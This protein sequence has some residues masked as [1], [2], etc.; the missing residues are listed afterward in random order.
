[1]KNSFKLELFL[2]LSVFCSTS[3]LAQDQQ[4]NANFEQNN[5]QSESNNVSNN[6][7]Q[8]A[9]ETSQ[10]DEE[11]NVQNTSLNGNSNDL[12]I[13]NPTNS[14]DTGSKGDELG[15]GENSGGNS[16]GNSTEPPSNVPPANTSAPELP[17]SNVPSPSG[18][19]VADPG[20]APSV[21]GQAQQVAIPGNPVAETENAD[22]IFKL[23][24]PLA[25]NEFTGAPSVPG[26]IKAF[27]EGEA[28]DLYRVEPGDT[29]I[30]ICDQLL[31]E[32]G[33]WPKLW[34]YNPDIRNPHFIWPG[35][36]LKF[37]SG[38][39]ETP[40]YL[41]ISNSDPMLPTDM[42]AG[43]SEASL[44]NS[45]FVTASLPQAKLEQIF[46]TDPDSVVDSM[47]VTSDTTGIDYYGSP[48]AVLDL[49]VNV[50]ALVFPEEKEAVGTILKGI[51]S[52]QNTGPGGKVIIENENGLAA[53]TIYTVLR[54]TGKL[55]TQSNGDR[56]GYRYEYAGKVSVFRKLKD[57]D[58]FAASVIEADRGIQ[59]GDIV[60]PYIATTRR[61]PIEEVTK[62]ASDASGEIVGFDYEESQLGATG[63]FVFLAGQNFSPG[64]YVNLYRNYFGE[65][66]TEVDHNVLFSQK[67]AVAR[68]LDFNSG[69]AT[70][71]I[72][73][74]HDAVA[75]GDKAFAE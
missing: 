71:Y 26:A 67:V 40:P 59:P 15:F 65:F 31:D 50:P 38:D 39:D 72:V 7:A 61:V 2:Y 43:M 8:N 9:S 64:S 28:P 57:D 69:I 70:G 44:I 74:S 45:P 47:Q 20:P 32:P 22:N 21:D 27:A 12:P 63:N 23:T 6:G 29:L 36:N 46:L 18:P 4:Q 75:I 49:Q 51:D 54:L 33:Y 17:P 24:S 62:G 3:T 37:F 53:G 19:V 5:A 10:E 11:E 52:N 16:G 30:D 1:M 25:N 14:A 58:Y 48:S 55:E 42:P 56:V 13:Q 68:I 34:S 41:Q 66:S 60:V 35:M 73:S